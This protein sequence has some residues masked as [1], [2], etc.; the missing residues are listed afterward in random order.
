MSLALLLNKLKQDMETYLES[1]KG[2]A[3]VNSS[4]VGHMPRELV[5][6]HLPMQSLTENSNSSETPPPKTD[7]IDSVC[8]IKMENELIKPRMDEANTTIGC[9]RS[10]SPLPEM[11]ACAPSVSTE[12]EPT[13]EM[14]EATPKEEMSSDLNQLD[15]PVSCAETR[16]LPLSQ[17]S[18]KEVNQLESTVCQLQESLQTLRLTLKDRN[19]EISKLKSEN[20]LSKFQKE[21]EEKTRET[22]VLVRCP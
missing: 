15:L 9:N 21:L 22:E 12:E 19:D 20:N 1:I 4:E 18:A 7:E 5:I 14:P 11:L 6:P 16:P 3:S 2:Q 10:S 13:I 8:A 17:E